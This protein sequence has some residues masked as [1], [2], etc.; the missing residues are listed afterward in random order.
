MVSRV[1]R[2]PRT[3]NEMLARRERRAFQ[4]T[5]FASVGRKLLVLMMMQFQFV[6]SKILVL[7]QMKALTSY[8]FQKRIWN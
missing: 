4:T 7:E 8:I 3:G 6:V 2:N 5:L 1:L